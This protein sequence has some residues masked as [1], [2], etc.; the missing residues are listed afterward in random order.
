MYRCLYFCVFVSLLA[1]CSPRLFSREQVSREFRHDEESD[2]VSLQRL[3]DKNVREQLQHQL[4]LS[5]WIDQV[6]VRERLSDPDTA[7][8]QHVTERTTTTMSRHT[9]A[10][11]GTS[12]LKE[13]HLREQTDST[14]AKR[15]DSSL[16]KEEEERVTGEVKGWMPWYVYVA[17]LLVAGIVGLI[18]AKN[19]L[20][21]II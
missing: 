12:V 2:S 20:K 13:E 18:L 8:R 11:A 5:E 14:H 4:E 10:A 19:R 15:E 7:G 3:V 16:L 17:A 21:G 9:S 6:T 1:S